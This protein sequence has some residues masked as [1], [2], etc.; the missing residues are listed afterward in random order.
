MS[1]ALPISRRAACAS[2]A[3]RRQRIAE[4]YLRILRFFRFHAWYGQG[5]PD[6][7]GLHACIVARAGLET[8]SRERVR[9]ELLK[10]LLA[11]HATPTLAVMAETGLLGAVLGGVP[12]LAS[13]ENMVKVEAAMGLACRRRAPARA[14]SASW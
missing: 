14:R 12:L 2:S 4:D 11:P 1:A 5:H 9:M 8:L 6:A 3:S 7:A 13:F 10:L